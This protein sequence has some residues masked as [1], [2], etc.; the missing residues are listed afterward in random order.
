MCGI[1][2]I[3]RLGTKPLP[4]PSVLRGMLGT[5]GFRGPGDTGEMLLDELQLGI[6]RLAIVDPKDGHQPIVGCDRGVV[7]ACNGEIYNHDDLRERLILD[8]HRLRSHS[9]AEVLPHLYEAH[10][11]DFVEKIRG[12]YG[13]AI[14]DHSRRKLVLVRDRLGIKP[15]F[16]AQTRDYLIFAS[17]IKAIIASG[18]AHPRIDMDSIDD[19]FSLSYPCPPRTMFEGIREILPAHILV[20]H[21]D[22]AA[23]TQRRY[24][25]LEFAPSGEYRRIRYR[26]AAEELRSLLRTSVYDHLKSDVPVG[27]YLSGGLD[28]SSICALVKEV[29]DC[30]QHSRSHS[31]C[32]HMMN[33]IIRERLLGIWEALPTRLIATPR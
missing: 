9:D 8:G 26:E 16:F 30:R 27:A 15:L 14:W 1:A 19:L 11:V 10:G 2:G 22:Q 23:I 5:I 4:A 7:A 13:L 24:W 18:L 21:S 28:S 3:L 31:T 20:A 6:V 32:H 33:P 29:G 12:M 17:E 25:N